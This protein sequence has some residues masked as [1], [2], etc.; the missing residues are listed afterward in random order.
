MYFQ[1]TVMISTASQ[2]HPKAHVLPPLHLWENGA[3]KS[4]FVRNMLKLWKKKKEKKS[5]S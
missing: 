1:Y 2:V 5:V 4:V 3:R